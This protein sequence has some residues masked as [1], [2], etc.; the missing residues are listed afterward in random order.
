LRR[1]R[2][3]SKA[4]NDNDFAR[5]VSRFTTLRVTRDPG[6]RTAVENLV[7]E[8]EQA[9]RGDLGREVRQ[10]CPSLASRSGGK[11]PLAAELE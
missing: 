4:H 7:G 9:K 10:A 5:L 1:V 6:V 3:L 8:L 11:R 2:S